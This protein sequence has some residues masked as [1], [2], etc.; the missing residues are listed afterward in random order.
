[1][2]SKFQS[3]LVGTIILVAVGVIVLPD[4]LDGKKLHYK[5]EFASIPIKPELDSDVENFEILEPVEDDIAL[6]DSP[7][8]AV[9]QESE[10]PQVAV[11]KPQPEPEPVAQKEETKQP[12]QVEVAARPV[13]EKNQYEDSAWIIQLMALKNHDNAVAL[14]ADLQ[15][16]GYQAHTKQ[17]NEFTRVI[18]GPD[19]SKSKLERQVQELQKI[20][21]SKGQ[22]LKFKPLNP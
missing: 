4:V 14:V 1:M 8:E 22:L 19:V 2:A 5:E 11:S 7:V 9:V 15:K 6:P 10:E 18:V 3:R 16:R 17:E 21:G 20:T 12:E 13:V